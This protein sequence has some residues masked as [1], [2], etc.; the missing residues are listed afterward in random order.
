MPLML[1]CRPQA[2]QSL[3]RLSSRSASKDLSEESKGQNATCNGAAVLRT[4]EPE[5]YRASSV[6]KKLLSL[7]VPH[8]CLAKRMG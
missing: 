2:L 8:T 4:K 1:L 3:G 7:A 6:L 5:F